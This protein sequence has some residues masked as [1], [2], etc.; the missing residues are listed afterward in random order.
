MNAFYDKKVTCLFCLDSFQTKRIRTRYVRVKNVHSDFY[1]EYADNLI[2]PHL[3]DVDVC[4]KCGFA[5]NESFTNHFS[6][7]AKQAVKEGFKGWRNQ[8]FGGERTES[9]AIQTKKLALYSAMLKQ[10][11]HIV[12]AG[13]CVRLAWIYR[14]VKNGEQELR[15]LERAL[16]QYKL[17]FEK[18]DYEGTQ[19][20]EVKLLYMI[21][22]VAR[23]AG[24]KEE[25]TSSF[26]RVIQHKY[27]Q[28]EPKTVE[29]A[30][31]QWYIIRN[32]DQVS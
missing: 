28:L 29:M 32:S 30:R 25:A 1:T 12:I 4:P 21:G 15:F 3:Y 10:E 27:R 8:D 16:Q 31:E 23:R 26:S 13:I 17:S 11:K 2:N 6:D 9:E 19:M 24:D 5:S 14:L 7:A 20:S 22:E 18:G